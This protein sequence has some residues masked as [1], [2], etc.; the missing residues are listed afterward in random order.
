M[1]DVVEVLRGVLAAALFTAVIM[2]IL[3]AG[4][5]LEWAMELPV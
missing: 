5:V 3:A 4:Q 1:R 2:V